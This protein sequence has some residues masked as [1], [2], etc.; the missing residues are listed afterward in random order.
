[1]VVVGFVPSPFA[2]DKCGRYL[3]MDA[4]GLSFFYG[5]RIGELP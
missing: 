4:A 5:I 1:M 3:L 2:K